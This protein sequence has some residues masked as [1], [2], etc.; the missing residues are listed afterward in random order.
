MNGVQR[1]V[2]LVLEDQQFQR[3]LAESKAALK[4]QADAVQEVEKTL[5]RTNERLRDSN[6]RFVKAGESAEAFGESARDG[7]EKTERL[8]DRIG[9]A[10]KRADGFGKTLRRVGGFIA[11]AFGAREVFD[12]V[13]SVDQ[14]T[15]DLSAITGIAGA[16]LERLTEVARA[17]AVE[18]GRAAVDQIEAMKLLAS[19][20]DLTSAELEEMGG[21]V[22]TLS[23]AAGVD[24]ATAANVVANSINQWGLA[25]SESGRLVNV[26]AAGSKEGAAEVDDLAL[27]LRDSGAAANSAGIS[28]E[29][30][31][32]ALEILA[33]N[34]TKGA[35]AGNELRNV[36][37]ILRTE[38]SKLADAGLAPVNFE[39]D[40]VAG[41][42]AKLRPLLGDAASMV[43]LFGRENISAAEIL[44]RNAEAVGT[45]TGAVTG[46]DTA[47]EQAAIQADTL[48]G[49]LAKLRAGLEE[50]AL[51]GFDR[52]G[53]SSRA[54]VQ[55]LTGLVRA[56]DDNWDAVTNV[57]KV[58]GIAYISTR[59]YAAA[60]QLQ[61]ATTGGLVAAES[62]RA[63]ATLAA[64]SATAAAR[65]AMIGFNAAVM[66]NPIGLLVGAIT[67]AIGAFIAFRS[68]TDD[69]TEA[70]RRQ[71]DQ[72][73]SLRESYQL[74]TE[75]QARAKAQEAGTTAAGLES[76]I[77]DLD[78]LIAARQQD[79]LDMGS[80]GGARGMRERTD[81]VKELKASRA[82]LTESLQQVRVGERIAQ[83]R[84]DEV[85]AENAARDREIAASTPTATAPAATSRA[86]AEDSSV[87]DAERRAER[88]VGM[89]NVVVEASREAADGLLA[90]EIEVQQERLRRARAFSEA[91]LDA[92]GDG[93]ERA[94]AALAVAE[95]YDAREAELDEQA[96]TVR[97]QAA[98]RA[99]RAEADVERARI[100]SSVKNAR[101][102][103]AAVAAVS[104]TEAQRVTEAERD[105]ALAREQIQTD[106]QADRIAREREH[107]DELVAEA[108]RVSDVMA[109][110]NEAAAQNKAQAK[111]A[112]NRRVQIL[113]DGV[114]A[115]LE[116]T[117]R[118]VEVLLAAGEIDAGEAAQ[119]VA[120]A[121]AHAREMLKAV[122]DE[123]LKLPFIAQ[124]TADAFVNLDG[125]IDLD[126][127]FSQPLA[128]LDEMTRLADDLGRAFEV[129]G[130]DI[131]ADVS[132]SFGDVTNAI[133]RAKDVAKSRDDKKDGFTGLAG[134]L[135]SLGSAAGVI[136]AAVG[137]M[138]V[139]KGALFGAAEENR[140]NAQA[141]AD[142]Q[143]ATEA[144][145]RA[146]LSG[147][148]GSDVSRDQLDAF[149]AGRDAV[150][151]AVEGIFDGRFFDTG[152]S[153]ANDA[154]GAFLRSLED[155]GL[156]VSEFQS[157]FDAARDLSAGARRDAFASILDDMERRF[158]QI[159]A[160]LGDYSADFAGAV[161]QLED[162]LRQLGLS[163]ADAL[164]A[165][166][167]KLR[168]ADLGP[169]VDGFLDTMAALEPGTDEYEAALRAF[170]KSVREGGVSLPSSMSMDDLEALL[171]SFRGIRGEGEG[172]AADVDRTNATSRTTATFAQQD[173]TNGY[174]QE[175]LRTV[176]AWFDW[177]RG[178]APASAQAATPATG[179][180]VQV[181]VPSAQ[182]A[183][184]MRAAIHVQTERLHADLAGIY[185]VLQAASRPSVST[186]TSRL[187]TEAGRAG[188]IDVHLATTVH[189]QLDPE[190]QAD[191]I[192]AAIRP[193]LVRELQ[194]TARVV[195]GRTA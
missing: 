190:A 47:M 103:A 49:D 53:G 177:A 143:R 124:K 35:Q 61:I 1:R 33:Q 109:R 149:D 15:A 193:K 130:S 116:A 62:V 16:D 136:T 34:G 40:G 92:I 75:E 104:A 176:R 6:G 122:A 87:A 139:L 120:D 10:D 27:S 99:A 94:R 41:T 128:D 38:S 68:R 159:G 23:V 191:A 156:D 164:D 118:D 141:L 52:S 192:L 111:D 60:T 36:I 175:I 100:G 37:T 140:R 165:F 24:L 71:Q 57:V 46:T 55:D 145:T 98:V 125:T 82:Y 162:D 76:Q 9:E 78:R 11:A 8:T 2:T 129:I 29:E 182:A 65:A 157:R 154:L 91:R 97:E 69:Q 79:I 30:T 113:A 155:A 161:A 12:T 108:K 3:G 66:A 67:L 173:V 160:S 89:N 132:R 195:R 4:R 84:A 194:P 43:K 137:A 168:E 107:A 72:V 126:G 133:G 88:I 110:M 102:K 181:A 28:F 17:N 114:A 56:L 19:N 142:A 45:M 101:E 39:A 80:Q 51:N 48:R 153:E 25:T 14:A 188:S 117:R 58:L 169:V 147:Q 166:V 95:H 115:E 44:I 112:P 74:L 167:A 150:R 93:E 85:A 50:L 172:G 63:T 83:E 152:L 184:A 22:V 170:Y 121:Q 127:S 7:A 151:E 81:L 178:G 123:M 32:G 13:A 183:E 189:S 31:V 73:N 70:L 179:D 26:L 135:A 77:A 59:A 187:G 21:Q 131:L 105:A 171:D 106:T 119:R 86:A 134:S 90:H 146:L 144:N 5:G 64:T 180:V 42:L 186:D 18:T 158:G 163:G 138:G 185:G 174:L 54:L 96:I 20:V 148:V